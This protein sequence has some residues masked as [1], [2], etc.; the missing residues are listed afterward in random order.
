MDR[1]FFIVSVNLLCNSFSVLSKVCLSVLVKSFL[2][3]P[4]IDVLIEEF[5]CDS[6]RVILDIF[7]VH[8]SSPFPGVAW[9]QYIKVDS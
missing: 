3:S 2:A 1:I 7:Y 8:V 5:T 4:T 6:S 9:V